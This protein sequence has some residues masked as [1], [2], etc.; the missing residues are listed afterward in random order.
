MS[1]LPNV[2]YDCESCIHYPICSI[3][4]EYEKVSAA[5]NHAKIYGYND[6]QQL[7]EKASVRDMEAFS[8]EV[9]CVYYRQY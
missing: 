7:V 9:K 8:V 2:K 3:V 5:V 4:D 1:E 6:E